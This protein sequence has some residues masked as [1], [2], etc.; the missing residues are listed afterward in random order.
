MAN[1][2]YKPFTVGEL[3]DMIRKYP[4]AT[5]ICVECNACGRSSMGGETLVKIK[6]KTG[7]AYGH[8]E[9]SINKGFR[10]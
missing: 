10:E 3:E 5:E 6:D 1:V 7:G 2:R 4:R 8:L 9:L